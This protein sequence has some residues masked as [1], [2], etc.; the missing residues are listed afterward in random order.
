M[1]HLKTLI[2]IVFCLSNAKF[3][4]AQI[5]AVGSRFNYDP[6][7][8]LEK[9]IRKYDPN[10][11]NRWNANPL[12]F[13]DTSFA[14][15]SQFTLGSNIFA[16]NVNAATAQLSTTDTR[17]GY[18]I[19]A[20][21]NNKNILNIGL[22]AIGSNNVATLFSENK[23]QG[24]FGVNLTWSGKLLGGMY[25]K[26][27]VANANIPLRVDYAHLLSSKAQIL[28][29]ASVKQRVT[30]SI[31]DYRQKLTQTQPAYN[32][33]KNQ[34]FSKIYYYQR[35]QLFLDSLDKINNFT[36]PNDFWNKGLDA[37][38]KK[39]AQW[40]GFW[41]VTYDVSG[42]LSNEGFNTYKLL[43]NP[44]NFPS[45]TSNAVRF[46]RPTLGLGGN[47]LRYTNLYSMRLSLGAAYARYIGFDDATPD[48]I[49]EDKFA[50]S[51]NVRRSVSKTYSAYLLSDNSSQTYSA[52]TYTFDAQALF[53][54]KKLFGAGVS[55]NRKHTFG[56]P[57]FDDVKNV[58]Y[59][60]L[61]ALSKKGDPLN[62]SVIAFQ[63]TTPDI[64]GVTPI[65]KNM[66][67]SRKLMKDKLILS[68]SFGLT[69]DKIFTK[70]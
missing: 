48:K 28:T 11:K 2:L 33:P 30:D 1:K 15:F 59:S 63:L 70:M 40:T 57:I 50:D 12:T 46:W 31:A 18:N 37:F 68:I 23:K 6:D 27:K 67:G 56:G 24:G 53:G 52:M 51:V 16:K 49:T 61:L 44:A 35:L 25:Y 26:S 3:T 19:A 58:T 17:L 22:F 45:I 36:N 8:L 5:A 47:F 43:S 7:G 14:L 29:D 32:N 55:A 64:S 69:L 38:D 66:D 60:L 21:V 13:R 4:T 34:Q 10:V 9:K 65:S 54:T 39:N 20:P 62:K 41:M 42:G